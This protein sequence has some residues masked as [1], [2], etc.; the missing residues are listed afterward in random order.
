[1]SRQISI[2]SEPILSVECNDLD[3]L[4]RTWRV[5]ETIRVWKEAKGRHAVTALILRSRGVILY[6]YIYIY[7]IFRI[8][9][10]NY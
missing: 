3:I 1:M 2:Y 10:L 6:I 4:T 5:F 7:I 8:I 9:F